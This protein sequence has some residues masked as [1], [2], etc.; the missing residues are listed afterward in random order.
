MPAARGAVIVTGACAGTMAV[1]QAY[2]WVINAKA[3]I[4]LSS[5]SRGEA[6]LKPE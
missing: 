6:D 3:A 2:P 5:S 1:S 4:V